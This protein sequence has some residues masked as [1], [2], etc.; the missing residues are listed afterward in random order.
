M[1][2]K[3]IILIAAVLIAAVVQAGVVKY[4]GAR[5][6]HYGVKPFPTP[7]EWGNIFLNMCD[8]YDNSVPTGVWIVG[9]IDD[10]RIKCSLEFPSDGNQYPNIDFWGND[11]HEEFLSYFDNIGVKVF[12]QVEPGNAD[13]NTLMDLVM[14]QYGHHKCVVGFGV[15]VEWY[16]YKSNPGTGKKATDAEAESWEAHLKSINQDYTLFV[17]HWDWRW[18]P[19]TYRGDLIFVNDGQGVD[20]LDSLVEPLA[21][22]ADTFTNSTVMYQVGYQ[23]DKKWWS[24]LDNPLKEIGDA[25]AEGVANP[26]QPIGIMWVDF[27][28]RDEIVKDSLFKEHPTPISDQND[29]KNLLVNKDILTVTSTNGSSQCKI[30][31]NGN[32]PPGSKLSIVTGTGRTIKEV[33]LRGDT[34]SYL[35]DF[36][37]NTAGIYFLVVKGRNRIFSKKLVI[38]R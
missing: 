34:K 29:S 13:V 11:R 14:E 9:A 27:S 38:T 37:N 23:S 19:P 4:A 6:S 7:K 2:S 32:V 8:Q 12:L 10:P 15:D 3:K 26:D 16:L 30:Y 25:L 1:I 22:W 21:T 36:K 24:L 28:I 18:M 17:K 5:S 20:V 31:L 33:R 35:Y